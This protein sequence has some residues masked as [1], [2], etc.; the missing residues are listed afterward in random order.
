MSRA[1]LD[2]VLVDVLDD[3]F[4]L[5]ELPV[6]GREHGLSLLARDS[7]PQPRDFTGECPPAPLEMAGDG[8]GNQRNPGVRLRADPL[9]GKARRSDTDDHTRAAVQQNRPA[10]DVWVAAELAL[11]ECVAQDDHG[12]RR[13]AAVRVTVLRR[14]EEPARRRLDAK[15]AEIIPRCAGDGDIVQF[16]SPCGR[17]GNRHAE[18]PLTLRG[19]DVRE[20]L[21]PGPQVEI[22]RK[23]DEPAW[24]AQLDELL[25]VVHWQWT[26]KQR[27][28]QAEECR[29]GANAECERQ[30]GNHGE[31]RGL[32]EHP[33]CITSILPKRFE[34]PFPSQ[35]THP[36]PDGRKT[37]HLKACRAHRLLATHA[38]AHLLVGSSLEILPKLLIVLPLDARS[39]VQSAES[40]RETI[41]YRHR[42]PQARDV[43]DGS[44][45]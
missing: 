25:G 21:L 27:V 13:L 23:G 11:P 32:P 1:K 45:I 12:S 29:V 15:Q 28:E 41:Q 20:D 43:F 37:A 42:S 5:E 8:E 7:R 30:H 10:D 26:K 18:W 16:D 3:P 33:R 6:Q 38:G 34:G 35:L 40:G 9:T 22:H 2:P 36:I 39:V 4:G 19:G 44:L 31:A 17:S 14:R 24:P